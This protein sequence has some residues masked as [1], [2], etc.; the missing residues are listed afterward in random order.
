METI[1]QLVG[2]LN[3][4][5]TIP[6][7][8]YSMLLRFGG[9]YCTGVDGVNIALITWQIGSAALGRRVE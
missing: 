9:K 2:A 3:A 8:A 4:C 1:T 5:P 6:A 7:Y